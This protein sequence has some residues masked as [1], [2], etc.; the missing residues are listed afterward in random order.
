MK[1]VKWVPMPAPRAKPRTPRAAQPIT[2]Y[3]EQLYHQREYFLEPRL[4]ADVEAMPA[5]AITNEET[6][7]AIQNLGHKATGVDGMPSQVVKNSQYRE[8]IKRKLTNA[9][10]EWLQKGAIP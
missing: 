7:A 6:V 8:T 4:R 3:I 10:N 2:E 1:M 9:F 5:L